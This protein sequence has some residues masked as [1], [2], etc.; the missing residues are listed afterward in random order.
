MIK[1]LLLLGILIF[2]FV[3]T[4]NSNCFAQIN[5]EM[6]DLEKIV[7]INS[8]ITNKDLE[9]FAIE[10]SLNFKPIKEKEEIQELL[11]NKSYYDYTYRDQKKIGNTLLNEFL[12]NH[13]IFTTD[14]LLVRYVASIGKYTAS[15]LDEQE[16]T[17]YIFGIIEEPVI[18]LYSF[19]GGYIF[20]TTAMLKTL[21]N[22]AQLSACFAREIGALDN[23]ITLGTMINNKE[24]FS[25]MSSLNDVLKT[26]QGEPSKVLTAREEEQAKE[27]FSDPFDT[28]DYFA[29][30]NLENLFANKDYL[31][32]KLL[33]K[34]LTI[35]PDYETIVKK[36]LFAVNSLK[37]SGYDVESAKDMLLKINKE[38][39][40]TQIINRTI[41]MEN[42]L[43]VDTLKSHRNNKVEGKYILM[44]NRLGF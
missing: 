30:P 1:K 4:I 19:P 26:K 18:K 37:E 27:P 33:K 12:T 40:Q 5:L 2:S 3:L 44:V 31:S 7:D 21:E 10:R 13:K 38:Q 22:E 6:T 14:P 20:I 34:Y 23:D 41:N 8:R 9:D 39:K 24:A 29:S 42:W 25:L 36:D 32:K 35:V 16:G 28:L 43:G 11:K 17:E 15:H